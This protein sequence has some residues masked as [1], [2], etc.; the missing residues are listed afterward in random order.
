MGRKGPAQNLVILT[1]AINTKNRK[2]IINEKI[3]RSVPEDIQENGKI[4]LRL[5]EAERW[6][7]M[8]SVTDKKIPSIGI[9]RS[10]WGGGE[11]KDSF[12]AKVEM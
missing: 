7:G 4:Q 9:V 3:I 1:I 2:T 12:G 8:S 10:I 6:E 11:F 5:S